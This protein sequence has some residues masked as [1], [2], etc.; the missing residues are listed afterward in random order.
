MRLDFVF[1]SPS[2]SYAAAM[3][4][5]LVLA[6]LGFAVL[7]PL[8]QG[9]DSE[10]G[11]L[12]L[13]PTEGPPK[14]WL[15][16]EWSDVSK[17]APTNAVW[18]VETGVMHGSEPRGTWLMSARPYTNFLL[19][20][21]FKLAPRGNSGLALRAPLRGDPAFDGLELQMADVRYNPQAK[22]SELT[23]GLYRAVPPTKQVYKPEAWNCYE[24]TLD[25]PRLKVVLNDETVQDLNLDAQQ[26]S[27]KRHDDTDAPPIKDRPRHGHLGFQELSRGGHVE[28]RNARIKELP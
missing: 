4:A 16:R 6:S 10:P 26:Q 2:G 25:G 11:F 27:V 1:Q 23:G 19:Q 12:P 3:K 14:G 20:F 17:P 24:I 5:I 18:R 8:V 15:V 7:A 9:A 28:I 13:F 22:D 21:E